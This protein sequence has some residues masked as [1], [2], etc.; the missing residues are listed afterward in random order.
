MSNTTTAQNKVES[1]QPQQQKPQVLEEDDEF[2]DF[3]VEG[4]P[5]PLNLQLSPTPPFHSTISSPAAHSHRHSQKAP[6]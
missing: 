1:D 4:M 6:S 2:E 3:P 5:T